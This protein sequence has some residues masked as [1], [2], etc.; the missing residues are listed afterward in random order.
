MSTEKEKSISALIGNC[1]GE[2]MGIA[3]LL[4]MAFHMFFPVVDNVPVLAQ[5][6]N[7]F[8]LYGFWGVDIFF[9]L[10]G[11]GLVHAVN[12]YKL[13]EFYYRRVR[14]IFIPFLISGIIY[15]LKYRWSVLHFLGAVSGFSFVIGDTHAI[16][17]FI[18]AIAVCYF[19]FPFYYRLLK[20][21]GHPFLFTI[22]LIIAIFII[23]TVCIYMGHVDRAIF[24]CRIP[25]FILGT[26]IEECRNDK[27]F[28]ISGKLIV[29]SI[30]VLIAGILVM[31]GAILSLVKLSYF[32]SSVIAVP[33]VLLT[34]VIF[35]YTRKE[36]LLRK[37]LRFLGKISLELYCVQSLFFNEFAVDFINNTLPKYFTSNPALLDNIV[38][39]IC[40]V[41]ISYLL[42]LLN[43]GIG[44]LTDK[45]FA[46]HKDTNISETGPA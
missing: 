26:M 29:T 45:L 7:F 37:L 24:I 14:R 38:I 25:V 11:M 22:V 21:I 43:T 23:E 44:K 30:I 18:P 40:C 15:A 16:L 35:S 12:K 1:R 28:N 17:W 39:F 20:K 34:S 4:L 42:Y 27:R 2:L 10:S 5:I 36:M 33:F 9:L 32:T 3:A 13:G 31:V 19:L 6:E 8:L 41:I 46:R